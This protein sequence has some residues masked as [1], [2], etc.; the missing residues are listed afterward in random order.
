MGLGAKPPPQLGQTF[1]MR[2][3]QW[4]QNVHSYVQIIASR[5]CGGRSLS[6]YSQLGRSSNAGTS[7]PCL[8]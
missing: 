5:A 4:A 6:Q 7:P 1:A 8:Q 2:S 3:T